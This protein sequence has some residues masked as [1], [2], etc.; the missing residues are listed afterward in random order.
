MNCQVKIAKGKIYQV[1]K[2]SGGILI[3]YE[4]SCRWKATYLK[5]CAQKKSDIEGVKNKLHAF[6][7]LYLASDYC[8]KTDLAIDFMCNFQYSEISGS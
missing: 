2:Y 4:T 7:I 3:L 6:F 1:F 8:N 5:T